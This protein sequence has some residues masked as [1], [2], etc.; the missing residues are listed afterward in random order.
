MSWESESHVWTI[1]SCADEAF[2]DFSPDFTDLLDDV[3][4]TVN[5]LLWTAAGH[6]E[7]GEDLASGADMMHIHRELDRLADVNGED[8]AA[9]NLVVVSGGQW[10]RLRLRDAGYVVPSLCPRCHEK[11]ESLFHRVW[12]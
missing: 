9:L 4:A 8:L 1:P 6:H 2:S 10:P 3:E 7:A 5:S 12:E 11:P